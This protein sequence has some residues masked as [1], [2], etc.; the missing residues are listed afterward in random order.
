MN[1]IIFALDAVRNKF[2]LQPVDL[3]MMWPWLHTVT[4]AKR[5]TLDGKIKKQKENTQDDNWT[6]RVQILV[7]F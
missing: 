6:T 2:H 3:D 5:R 7:Y 1:L 4:L